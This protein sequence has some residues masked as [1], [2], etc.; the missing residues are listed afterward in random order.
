MK[1]FYLI[2]LFS[3]NSCIERYKK[4]PQIVKWEFEDE[5]WRNII[6]FKDS[7][8][9]WETYNDDIV[10]VNSGTFLKIKSKNRNSLITL[11]LIPNEEIRGDDKN[12][13]VY[14][15]AESIDILSEDDS[16]VIIRHSTEIL[17][18]NIDSRKY[19]TK[20]RTVRKTIY[21]IK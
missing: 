19:I 13:S 18:S 7:L 8:F 16:S 10:S 20:K 2:C 15:D 3:F 5:K 6:T 21:N 11:V 9:S 14:L 12:D 17:T 1:V 4:K